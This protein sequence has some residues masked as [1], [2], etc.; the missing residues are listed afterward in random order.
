MGKKKKKILKNR[1]LN[2]SWVKE[3]DARMLNKLNNSNRAQK[4]MHYYLPE[5]SRSLSNSGS[6]DSCGSS[7]TSDS[8]SEQSS[9]GNSFKPLK[10]SK[11]DD[12][13]RSLKEATVLSSK[14][15]RLPT[16]KKLGP[17]RQGAGPLCDLNQRLRDYLSKAKKNVV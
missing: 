11:S 17:I 4:V 7:S 1:T 3:G 12:T 10:K 16:S 15:T 9:K 2:E 13:T 14:D 5:S 8:E 6:S